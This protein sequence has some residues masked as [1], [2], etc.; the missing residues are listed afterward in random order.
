M[1]PKSLPVQRIGEI[2]IETRRCPGMGRS[3]SAMPKKT[4]PVAMV[5]T[6]GCSRP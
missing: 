6:I 1:T 4:A 2:R 3:H 5:A